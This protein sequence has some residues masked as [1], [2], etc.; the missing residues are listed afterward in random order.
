[1]RS[2]ARSVPAARTPE[3]R[4][5][6]AAAQ[7]LEAALERAKLAR[8]AVDEHVACVAGHVVA[9]VGG[10]HARGCGRCGQQV[11][12]DGLPK[13]ALGGDLWIGGGG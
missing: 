2:C 6:G 13:A 3:Q 8:H 7:P 11:D 12:G 9:H 5:R 4:E 1:M 10:R